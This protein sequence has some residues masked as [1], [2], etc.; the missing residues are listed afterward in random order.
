LKDHFKNKFPDLILSI[1]DTPTCSVVDDFSGVDEVRPGNFVFYDLKQQSIGSCK[2]DEI[3]ICMACPVVAKHPERN[4]IVL[5]GGAVHFSKD[6]LVT[7]EGEKCYGYLV[8]FDA[9]GWR[10]PK[11]CCYVKSL[12]QE[13]GIL[14]ACDYH[15]ERLKIGDIVGILPVHACLTSNLMKSYTTL[16]GS[17]ITC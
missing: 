5:Y 3:A 4:E 1:G 15:F 2:T 16:E 12:S 8:E 7:S 14:K 9:Q 11:R 6:Y 13:H 17:I 10:M